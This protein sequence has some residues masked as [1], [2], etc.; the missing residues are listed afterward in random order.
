MY[1]CL[2]Y[3]TE[4]ASPITG[5]IICLYTVDDDERTSVDNGA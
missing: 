5:A 2:V 3:H 4:I 1:L